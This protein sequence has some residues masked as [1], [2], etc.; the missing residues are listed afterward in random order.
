MVNTYKQEEHLSAIKCTQKNIN[1][2]KIEEDKS[3]SPEANV[4]KLPVFKKE[5]CL[6]TIETPDCFYVCLPDWVTTRN[7]LT[8]DMKLFYSKIAKSL[9]DDWKINDKCAALSQKENAW[10]RGII[11]D[12]VDKEFTVFLKDIGKKETVPVDNIMPLDD[13]F[14][15]VRDLTIRCSLAGI[16]PAGG[17][18]KWTNTAVEVFEEMSKLHQNL[19]ITK[20]GDI[21]N[22]TLPV[23]LY[24]SWEEIVGPLDPP[25]VRHMI[26]N[27]R[28]IDEGVALPAK[29]VNFEETNF[30]LQPDDDVFKK[31]NSIEEE[32]REP[33]WL[34]PIPFTQ[35]KF[36]AIP[37]YVD[38][39]GYVYLHS[40]QLETN[41]NHIKKILNNKFLK[42]V[43]DPVHEW[44]PDQ[45]CTVQY[46]LDRGYYRARV[47]RTL[48]NGHIIV[49]LI[50]YGNEEECTHSDLRSTAELVNYPTVA[51]KCKLYNVTPKST[52][53]KW[54]IP[55]L[56]K[57]HGTIVEKTV[58]V[59]VMERQVE[60]EPVNIILVFEGININIQVMSRDWYEEEQQ[61]VK[62]SIIED[63]DSDVIIEGSIH[64][65]ETSEDRNPDWVSLAN[66]EQLHEVSYKYAEMPKDRKTF[67][68]S[69][70]N[71][72][73]YNTV[74][75]ECSFNSDMVNE[76][77]EEFGI[78]EVDINENAANQ[79]PVFEPTVGQAC[80]A[81]YSADNKWY[82]AEIYST[83]YLEQT[84]HVQVL[85]IDYGNLDDVPRENLRM[86]RPEWGEFPVNQFKCKIYG[87]KKADEVSDQEA[88]D[89]MLEMLL[90]KNVVL[91]VR[92][93]EPILEAS[94]LDQNT[95]QLVYGE[96]VTDGMFLLS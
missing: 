65:S 67:D 24:A 41:L 16:I 11:L 28:L 81:Q 9:K 50:D 48:D 34:P 20:Q 64:E 84:G 32:K 21:E 33:A 55:L 54:P 4:S 92:K 23:Y 31:D 79:P 25:T 85:F 83:E 51:T 72:I 66:F 27:K 90:D 89:R 94:L 93:T 78:L 46:Y 77:K 63:N 37:T 95:N 96:G 14:L 87:L 26:I 61:E 80:C 74:I 40:T 5:V 13:K 68:C 30:N 15:T 45:L 86:L 60:G 1:R 52:D 39:D 82:R 49:Q 91:Y 7:K 69:I 88:T 59:E 35:K 75:I 29:G 62:G 43:P 3:T 18:S 8:K 2:R 71:V 44:F 73:N 19:F 6:L 17:S 38:N 22:N 42:S 57:L 12:I 70:I 56:D 58:D 47:I 53:G 36:K 76:T 10:Y